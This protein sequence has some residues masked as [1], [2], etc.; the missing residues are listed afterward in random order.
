M[1]S[2]RL[3]YWGFCL[4]PQGSAQTDVFVASGLCTNPSS[5]PGGTWGR[6]GGT[7]CCAYR[8][9]EQSPR[10]LWQG[11]RG[12]RERLCC[13][14]VL[15]GLG[16]HRQ[17]RGRQGGFLAC[18]HDNGVLAFVGFGGLICSVT[19]WAPECARPQSSTRLALCQ[20]IWC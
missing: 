15:L 20:G 18:V 6:G 8:R 9:Q 17:V 12:C 13:W 5:L 1:M 2:R 7:G 16:T 14:V 4:H 3:G 19:S 10:S 11:R